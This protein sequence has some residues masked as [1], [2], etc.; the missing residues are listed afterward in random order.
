MK[1]RYVLTKKQ[2]HTIK[3][4]IENFYHTYRRKKCHT[5]DLLKR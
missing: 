4:G 5:A 3:N 2:N 1:P